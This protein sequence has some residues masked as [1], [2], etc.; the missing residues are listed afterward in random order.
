MKFNKFIILALLLIISNVYSKLSTLRKSHN[1]LSTLR[2]K[3]YLKNKEAN[4]SKVGNS[5]NST[6]GNHSSGPLVLNSLGRKV[7]VAHSNMIVLTK[8]PF[9]VTRCDEVVSF[10]GEF[11]TNINEY[12]SRS[13]GFFT[14]TAHYSNLFVNRNASN[15]LKS[16]IMA[17]TPSS[18]HVLDGTGGCIMIQ[19]GEGVDKSI[20]IC[21]NNLT[22]RTNILGVLKKFFECR[23]GISNKKKLLDPLKVAAMIK[24]CSNGK[25][26]NPLDLIK[27]LTK[28]QE[29]KEMVVR[30]NANW[31]HPGSD[32]VPGTGLFR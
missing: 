14:L 29:A 11:I 4:K 24:Q 30:K 8:F 28:K 2:K 23:S 21:L 7:F 15:L 16:I 26:G 19:S 20:T 27:K 5:T 18:P 12:R 17:E 9:E 10:P 31:F 32:N 3:S 1:K 6:K 25:S 13:K 22:H